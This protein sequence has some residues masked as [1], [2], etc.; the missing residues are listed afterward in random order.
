K[1]I[2]P[3]IDAT[4]PTYKVGNTRL[5]IGDSL[6][7]SIALMTAMTYPTI[8]SQVALLSPMYNENIKQKFDTCMNKDQLTIWHAIGLEEEDFILPT[9]GK[10]ANFLTPNR[11]LNQ[12][13]KEGNT[14]YFYKEFKG[15]HHWKSWK[16]LLGDILLK[17]LSNQ[18]NGKY[19]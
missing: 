16:P 7:G 17:F 1:E 12:L 2:L 19:V 15:G 18:I 13:I 14:E 8:F 5:L 6:A 3:Y 10:R 11:E 9:N 4:F